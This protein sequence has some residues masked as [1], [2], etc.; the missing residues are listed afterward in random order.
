MGDDKSPGEDGITAKF[1]KMFWEDIKHEFFEY[2]QQLEKLEVLPENVGILWLIL[3]PKKDL[4]S[5]ASWR[6]I[7][8]QAVD[9]KI[10][11]KAIANRLKIAIEE[12]IHQ[13]QIGFRGGQYIG[14]T[15][16][17]IQD[18]IEYSQKKQNDA[19]LISLDIEKAFD[20]VEWEYLDKIIEQMDMQGYMHNWI[21]LARSNMKIKI[22]NNGWISKPME[23]SRGL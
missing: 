3:K 15:I 19:Y 13:D 7:C 9:L 10:I 14:Q 11:T 23:V 8:L 6:P 20:S 21:K 2:T 12:V 22:N 4:L 16:Q 5:V 1:Y 18:V 17:L